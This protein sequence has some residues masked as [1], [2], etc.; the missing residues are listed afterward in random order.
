MPMIH[1]DLD[2][3]FE[4]LIPEEKSKN[5]NSTNT[6]H[7][8]K[9]GRVGTETPLAEQRQGIAALPNNSTDST[10][11]TESVETQHS[12]AEE[13]LIRSYLEWVDRCVP[14]DEWQMQQDWL[15]ESDEL[16]LVADAHVRQRDSKLRVWRTGEDKLICKV[17]FGP[18]PPPYRPPRKS[19]PRFRGADLK[20]I[21]TMWSEE[22]QSWCQW[23]AT[24]EDYVVAPEFN[25]ESK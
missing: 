7:I 19:T 16:R 21:Q 20:R 6:E 24:L 15:P 22:Y 25:R 1:F 4:D 8:D 11:S 12:P 5:Q 17:W 10:D 3:L 14:G 9:F 18:E 2:E 23:D 13:S